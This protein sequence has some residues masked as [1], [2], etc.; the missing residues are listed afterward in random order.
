MTR[1]FIVALL[2]VAACSPT[3]PRNPPMQF[4]GANAALE[5]AIDADDAHAVNAA[6]AAGASANARGAHG[7]TPLEY[8]VGTFRRQA[9][10]AL[11]REHAN[12]NLKDDEGD[13][14]VSIAVTG[15]KRDPALLEMVLAAGG[16][17]NSTRPD[18]DP[19]IVRFLNDANLDAITF[20]H[21][22]GADINAKVKDE[23][24]VLTYA[25]SE[26]W[27]VVWKL[28]QLG[29]STDSPRIREGLAFAFK[30]PQITPPDS[31]LYPAKVAV[32]RH[33][34]AQGINVPA[35]AGM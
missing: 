21:K 3:T 20:L 22:H 34:H 17:P 32:W 9:A 12:P 14:A 6:I 4:T 26:D 5:K 7:V 33:L 31:P 1:W 19:V 10:T 8:A 15:Y 28:I 35:P 30:G 16:D 2:V 27:D 23:P 18:G 24:M 13:N 11:I 29:A 25:I